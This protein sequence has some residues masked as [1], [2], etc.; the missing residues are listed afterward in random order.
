[1]MHGQRNVKVRNERVKLHIVAS[2]TRK[3]TQN[4][5]S[6]RWFKIG[7]ISKTEEQKRK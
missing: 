7:F 5:T 6:S 4:Y 2:N 1:M 3:Y